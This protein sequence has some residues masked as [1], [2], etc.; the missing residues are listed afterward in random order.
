MP[1]TES[2][3]IS[4]GEAMTM[5]SPGSWGWKGTVARH[6]STRIVVVAIACSISFSIRSTEEIRKGKSRFP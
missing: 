3:S 5:G 6:Y 1:K 4:I 2:R